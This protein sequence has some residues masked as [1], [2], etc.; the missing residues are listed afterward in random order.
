MLRWNKKEA[1]KTGQLQ[2]CRIY[3]L[4]RNWIGMIFTEIRISYWDEDLITVFKYVNDLMPE[5]EKAMIRGNVIIK[6]KYMWNRQEYVRK[7]RKFLTPEILRIQNRCRWLNKQTNQPFFKCRFIS[8]WGTPSN[9]V[10]F[11]SRKTN[12]MN[13]KVLLVFTK[14]PYFTNFSC[15][16]HCVISL[17]VS[18]FPVTFSEPNTW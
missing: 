16:C 10:F 2:K 15:S 6:S 11:N 17:D 3:L 5:R 9:M 4:R 18:C 14:W 7:R 13:Y 8:L 12:L 1:G